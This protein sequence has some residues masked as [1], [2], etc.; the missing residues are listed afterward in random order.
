MFAKYKIY[1]DPY[2]SSFDYALYGIIKGNISGRLGGDGQK[3]DFDLHT[4]GFKPLNAVLR[5]VIRCAQDAS[6]E[7]ALDGG[8]NDHKDVNFSLNQFDFYDVW[9]VVYNKGE[10]VIKHN[11]FPHSLSFVYFVQAPEGSSPL[12][13]ENERIEAVEGRLV[14][15]LS[16]QFHSCPPARVNGRCSLVGNIRIVNFV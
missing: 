9:G 4:K 5:W 3:T 7:F 11:H 15:F 2:I 13:I 16:H 12:I 6:Q 1:N 10:G 8:E 14:I